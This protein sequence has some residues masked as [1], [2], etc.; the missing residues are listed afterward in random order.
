MKT[1]HLTTVDMSLRYLILPQLLAAAEHGEVIGISAPGPYVEELESRGIRHV[2]LKS[3][4]RG[5]APLSDLK[6]ALQLWRILK[7]ERVDILHTHNPKPGVY[8]RI[9]GRLAGVPIVVNTIHGLY[10]SDDAPFAKKAIVYGL[11]WLA[12]RFSDLE[13]V[14]SPEDYELLLRSGITPR[15]KTQLLGNGV[16]LH[17]FNPENARL[18]R[19]EV[20]SELG[21]TPDDVVVGMVGRLVL[22]K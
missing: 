9:V 16:D 15:S 4:T 8:G 14:Q 5:A 12:S 21:V 19:E 13:L 3:S 1:A 18:H 7:D 17:R 22:E 6:A 2:P 20:R 11:E 10:A